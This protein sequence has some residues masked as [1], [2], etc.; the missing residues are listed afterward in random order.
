MP[1]NTSH[2]AEVLCVVLTVEPRLLPVQELQRGIE[3]DTQVNAAK[4]ENDKLFITQC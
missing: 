4:K 2:S 1:S 3:Q